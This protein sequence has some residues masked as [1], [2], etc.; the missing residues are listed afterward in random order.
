MA[1]CLR[2][3]FIQRQDYLIKS[4]FSE[5][6]AL[7]WAATITILGW[8]KVIGSKRYEQSKNLGSTHGKVKHLFNMRRAY[9]KH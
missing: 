6:N 1:T 5:N 7:I 4:L 9:F 8:K 3:N 2:F